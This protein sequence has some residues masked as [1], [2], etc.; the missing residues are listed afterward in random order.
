[1]MVI[2]EKHPAIQQ[3]FNAGKFVVH[4]T[5]NKLSAMAV[6]QCHEQNNAAVEGPGG[7][8]GLAENPGALRRWMV[9]EITRVLNNLRT[10]ILWKHRRAF[11]AL[12]TVTMSSNLAYKQPS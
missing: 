8:V 7:A 4:K 9:P 5:S 1:M 12:E 11:R 6:D 10:S 3:E 2:S